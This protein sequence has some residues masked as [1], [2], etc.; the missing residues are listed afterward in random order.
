M[1][2]IIRKEIKADYAAVAGV[3]ESAFGQEGEALL[4][5]RLRKNPG[6][7]PA[8]S[9]VAECDG[10]VVGHVL[11]FPIKIKSKEATSDSLALAPISVM[12]KFQ[13]KGIGGKLIRAGLNTA[14]D[15]GHTSVIVL[16]HAEYY[17]AFGF[18]PASKWD[19]RPPFKGVPD[20]AFLA[21]ELIDGALNNVSGVVEYPEEFNDV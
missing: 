17:P 21:I 19:I 9:L 20:N 2:T 14:I 12:P 13:R 15:L 10:R 3:I 6:F 7:I 8:L 16:G 4:V 18:G 11:F 1:N 5:Q